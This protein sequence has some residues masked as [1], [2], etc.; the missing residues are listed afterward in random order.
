MG[1]SRHS[2]RRR[3]HAWLRAVVCHGRLLSSSARGCIA[4]NVTRLRAK[5]RVVHGDSYLGWRWRR[6]AT[7]VACDGGTT[8]RPQVTTTARPDSPQTRRMAIAASLRPTLASPSS[9]CTRS[10]EIKLHDELHSSPRVQ[11]LR[12]KTWTIWSPIY[13][14]FSLISKW[15]RS[16]RCFDPSFRL[17]YASIRTN[18]KGMNCMCGMSS[19]SALAP[20][21]RRRLA[22]PAWVA[23]PHETT[24]PRRIATRAT[25]RWKE[26]S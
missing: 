24:G 2:S 5:L 26:G 20:W 14:G 15:I 9:N 11:F 4:W 1:G 10:G 7:A 8:P 17:V 21:W 3:R 6:A 23:R 16:W 12:I 25:R 19:D 13:M 18:R 22:G